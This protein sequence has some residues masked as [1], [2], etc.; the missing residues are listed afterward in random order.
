MPVFGVLIFSHVH[1]LLKPTINFILFIL[2]N[3]VSVH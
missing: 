3:F 2:G 1:L